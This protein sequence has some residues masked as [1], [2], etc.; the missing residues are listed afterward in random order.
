M[1][2]WS[3]LAVDVIDRQFAGILGYADLVDQRYAWDSNSLTLLGAT[4]TGPQVGSAVA[5][6]QNVTCTC[7]AAVVAVRLLQRAAVLS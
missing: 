6:P 4:T 2:A 7:R 5:A 1:A 3:L